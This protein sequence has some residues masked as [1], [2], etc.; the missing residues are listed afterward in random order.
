MRQLVYKYKDDKEKGIIKIPKENIDLNAYKSR[1]KDKGINLIFFNKPSN[2]TIE[3]WID[4]GIA[5][6]IDG[7]RIEL[8]GICEHGYPSILRVMGM[9]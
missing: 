3:N 8:D 5:C 1:H 9:V 6:S 2:N 4:N 7:C